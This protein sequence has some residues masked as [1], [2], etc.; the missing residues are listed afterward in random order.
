MQDCLSKQLTIFYNKEYSKFISAINK[1]IYPKNYNN[2]IPIDY[3]STEA[4]ITIIMARIKNKFISIKNINI[5]N[6]NFEK[7][8]KI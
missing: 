2:L 6:F 7:Y 8:F 4:A 3:N 1:N 5:A